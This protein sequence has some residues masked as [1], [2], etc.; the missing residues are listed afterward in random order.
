[1]DMRAIV[2]GLVVAQISTDDKQVVDPEV[3]KQLLRLREEEKVENKNLAQR[4]L[5]AQE[6]K[7]IRAPK[8]P[9]DHSSHHY[10]SRENAGSRRRG[11]R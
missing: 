7:H 1:M 5:K 2:T 4:N 3:E 10:A 8:P 9:H 11:P 6:P